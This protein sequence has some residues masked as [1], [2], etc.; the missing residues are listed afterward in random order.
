MRAAAK[1][2]GSPASPDRLHFKSSHNKSSNPHLPPA[3][4]RD[5]GPNFQGP[6]QARSASSGAAT[7]FKSMAYDLKVPKTPGAKSRKRACGRCGLIKGGGHLASCGSLLYI[8]PTAGHVTWGDQASH[9]RPNGHSNFSRS[10][11]PHYITPAG[12]G[13][14]QPK[15]T[16][17]IASQ[18]KG[19]AFSVK[20]SGIFRKSSHHFLPTTIGSNFG[21]TSPH[22]VRDN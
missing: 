14:T 3:G 21:P 15:K 5:R 6:D 18:A 19:T 17:T 12:R 7:A 20:P 4:K 9:A 2:G 11:R 13:E 16:L 8:K 10:R 22:T 1:P